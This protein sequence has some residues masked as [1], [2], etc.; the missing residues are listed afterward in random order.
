MATDTEKEKKEVQDQDGDAT[1]TLSRSNTLSRSTTRSPSSGAQTTLSR[2]RAGGGFGMQRPVRSVKVSTRK[3][4]RIVVP[5]GDTGELPVTAKGPEAPPVTDVPPSPPP[6]AETPAEEV[7]AATQTGES[8]DQ[9]IVARATPVAEEL[10]ASEAEV[11]L[12]P[13]V[14]VLPEAEVEETATLEEP[15]EAEQE[16]AAAESQAEEPAEVEAE[17][18]VETK[19]TPQKPRQPSQL[20]IEKE[21]IRAQEEKR[22]VAELQAKE[23]QEERARET[24]EKQ[25]AERLANERARQA[26]IDRANELRLKKE[27]EQAAAQALLDNRTSNRGNKR[28]DRDRRLRRGPRSGAPD[29]SQGGRRGRSQGRYMRPRGGSRKRPPRVIEIETQ[30]GEFSKP[31]ERVVRDV[32]ISEAVTVGE[33]A[34]RMSVKA[35]EVIKTLLDLGVMATINQTIDQDSA[36]LVVEEM[37]HRPK[38]VAE[39]RA[40]EAFE[41][42][43]KV[44]GEAV[45]R[46]PVVT[47]M[48][49]VDHGKTSLLDYI[50][51]TRVVSEEHGGITQH[52]GAYHLETEHGAVTFLDTPGHA[53]FSAMRARGANATDIVILVCAADD[54]VMPQTQEAVQH[55]LAA[56]VPMI[57]AVNKIDLPGMDP[58]RVKNELSA[59]G[60]VP[61]DWGGDTQFVNVSAETGEGIEELLEAISLQ[62]EILELEAVPEAT[63]R[64]VVIE[65]KLDRGRGPVATLLVNNGTLKKGDVL[66][67]GQCYGKVRSLLTDSGEVVENAGPSI[68]VEMLGLNGTPEAGDEFHVA[69]DERQ[70]RQISTARAAQNQEKQSQAQQAARLENMFANVAQGEKRVLKIVLKADVRGSLEAITQACDEIGND[71]VSVQI[72]GSGVGGISESDANMAVAYGAIII[73]FNVRTDSPAKSVVERSNVDVR[74]Y[75]IIYELLEDIR[76]ALE[77][78]LSPEVREEIVGTAEVRDIFHSPRFGQIAGCMVVEGTVARNKKIRVLRDSTV[79][80]QGELESLRRFKDDVN[81]VRNGF[82][83]GIG[84]RNYT[85]VREGDRIEVYESR[86]IA[87]AL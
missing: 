52:I 14:D 44:E 69:A 76:L 11:S 82:E 83:C 23:R 31:V 86:E 55:S 15:N 78:M 24:R 40:Q 64:G 48:G 3:R 41:S 12:E 57:V 28:S 10:G 61:E 29:R 13:E 16:V 81:E 5:Q 49:H 85:D 4:R 77:G 39:D 67:A 75:S 50:R 65:S 51:K 32:E 63:G 2:R 45:S 35:S 62:A 53:A 74:Y 38:I 22:I 54:G 9:E 59:I 37:G 6:V 26:A 18:T 60:V 36:V 79:I 84:V 58:E 30:G 8:Q 20:D 1:R 56:E 72:L 71:E 7:Q 25:E 27:A 43:Q 70:A 66:L 19:R 87:R 68:P 21:R 46:S 80:Y 17:R 34:R 42:Q 47:V 73:G 33:L